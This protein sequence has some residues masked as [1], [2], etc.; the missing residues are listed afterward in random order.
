MCCS[1]VV[2]VAVAGVAVIFIRSTGEHVP[3]RTIGP[4]TLGDDFFRVKYMWNGHETEHCAPLDCVLFPIPF[5]CAEGGVWAGFRYI[6][7]FGTARRAQHGLV[8]AWGPC[9]T[10]VFLTSSVIAKR[11]GA[12][13][14]PVAAESG[15]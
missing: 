9:L 8:Q 3:P 15:C 7:S 12:Y 10:V 4:S 1:A 6:Q 11:E 13:K 5:N 2:H 14:Q